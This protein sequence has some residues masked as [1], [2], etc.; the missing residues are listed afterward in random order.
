MP[1]E[2]MDEIKEKP[3]I[4]PKYHFDFK[5]DDSHVLAPVLDKGVLIGSGTEFINGAKSED[6]VNVTD[7]LPGVYIQEGK[8]KYS[9]LGV[10][11]IKDIN[12]GDSI[13]DRYTLV[14]NY[15]LARGYSK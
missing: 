15:A 13:L 4:D 10:L 7:F 14:E 5:V 12:P 1:D 9:F 3:K 11:A 2:K 6:R 8:K